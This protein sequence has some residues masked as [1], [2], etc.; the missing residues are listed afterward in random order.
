MLITFTVLLNQ[1]AR[2][3]AFSLNNLAACTELLLAEPTIVA[4]LPLLRTLC[5]EGF[6]SSH[7]LHMD[8]TDFTTLFLMLFLSKNESIS[9]CYVTVVQSHVLQSLSNSDHNKQDS[10]EQHHS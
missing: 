10:R 5:K 6:L 2:F 8:L 9:Q 1:K 4:P 3:I 7:T